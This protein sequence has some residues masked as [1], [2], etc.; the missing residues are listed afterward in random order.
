M[1]W[2]E[3]CFGKLKADGRTVNPSEQAVR[4]STDQSVTAITDTA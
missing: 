1:N 4:L 3:V 2:Q